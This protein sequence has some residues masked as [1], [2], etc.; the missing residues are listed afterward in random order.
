MFYYGF[1]KSRRPMGVG[2]GVGV[3][4]GAA[5]DDHGVEAADDRLRVRGEAR[6]REEEQLRQPARELV[7]VQCVDEDAHRAQRLG[8]ERRLAEEGLERR[9]HLWE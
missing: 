8:L 7:G 1:P 2:A 3:E 6:Q 9:D 5:L 4:G